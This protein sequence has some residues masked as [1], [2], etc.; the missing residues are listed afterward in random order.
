MGGGGA[1]SRTSEDRRRAELS[2]GN[3][4]VA[5][6]GDCQNNER[7]IFLASASSTSR[8]TWY[9]PKAVRLGTQQVKLRAS[10]EEWRFQDEACHAYSTRVPQSFNFTAP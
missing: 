6:F 8:G 4:F 5:G 7:V 10:A 2:G 3:G 9:S 1:K